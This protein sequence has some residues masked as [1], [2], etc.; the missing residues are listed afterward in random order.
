MKSHDEHQNAKPNKMQTK[1]QIKSDS[2]F[3]LTNEM[4]S[5]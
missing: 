1:P 2:F 3:L 4:N 5:L